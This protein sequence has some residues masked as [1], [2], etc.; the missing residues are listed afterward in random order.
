MPNT[1]SRCAC[2]FD[3][4][5]DERTRSPGRLL[6][7]PTES[8]HRIHPV[9]LIEPQ[10]LH[11]RGQMLRNRPALDRA[12]RAVLL[13]GRQRGR[14]PAHAPDP[15]VARGVC[16]SCPQRRSGA[17][18]MW[19][20]MRLRKQRRAFATECV[21]TITVVDTS[22]KSPYR[23]KYLT[24]RHR[25]RG[26]VLDLRVPLKTWLS[27]SPVIAG[28]ERAARGRAGGNR[29]AARRRGRGAA[30]AADRQGY[31]ANRFAVLQVA[32]DKVG[33]TAAKGQ[34][35]PEQVRLCAGCHS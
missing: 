2:P 34:V 8:A 17:G 26:A 24:K 18:R 20:S 9:R 19:A 6:E 7:Q 4:G 16:R 12:E 10:P 35:L 33:I 32:A 11:E 25:P 1:V 27:G 29:V 5:I 30:I 13:V 28:R 31:R 3:R 23:V 14:D 22:T 15:V 21:S